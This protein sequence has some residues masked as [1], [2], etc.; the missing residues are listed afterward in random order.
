MFIDITPAVKLDSGLD[1]QR[2]ECRHDTAYS[3][4]ALIAEFW[5]LGMRAAALELAL[6]REAQALAEREATA[7]A[8]AR[9]ARI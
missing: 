3:V 2:A 6:S 9:R 5:P 7:L 4:I 1:S 8:A